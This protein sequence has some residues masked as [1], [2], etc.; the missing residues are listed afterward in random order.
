[1]G[2]AAVHDRQ[3]RAD[4]A[5]PARAVRAMAA[6]ELETCLDL[7]AVLDREVLFRAGFGKATLQTFRRVIAER[8]DPLSR[9]GPEQVD[10]DA[11]DL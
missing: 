2:D 3:H 8:L 7:A 11:R 5:V 10:Q 4:L 9:S 1:M 6:L